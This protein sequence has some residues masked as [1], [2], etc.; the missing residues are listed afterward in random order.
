MGCVSGNVIADRGY[1]SRAI[2]E[3]I[4]SQGCTPVIPARSCSRPRPLDKHTY[5]ERCLVEC[6]F[7][8]VKRSRRI[9]TRFEKLAVHFAAMITIA[10]I[11]VWL[12]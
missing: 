3:Q 4:E 9:A 1:D 12:I 5:K 7:Q 6:L 11:R 8:K 2:I 10:F